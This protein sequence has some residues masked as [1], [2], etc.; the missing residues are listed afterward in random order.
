M[1]RRVHMGG[2][3][4]HGAT[5]TVASRREAREQTKSQ[6]GDIGVTVRARYV[7]S[8]QVMQSPK[9]G[10]AKAPPQMPRHDMPNVKLEMRTSGNSSFMQTASANFTYY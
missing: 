6:G 1:V 8:R 3:A 2:C 7:L 4:L 5:M 10:D 9:I